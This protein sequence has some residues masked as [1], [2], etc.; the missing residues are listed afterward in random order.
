MGVGAARLQHVHAINAPKRAPPT[1]G[2]GDHTL[3]YV[4]PGNMSS[5]YE[6]T[7]PCWQEAFPSCWRYQEIT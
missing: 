2:R 6:P 5:L 7:H 1:G 3:F 4:R